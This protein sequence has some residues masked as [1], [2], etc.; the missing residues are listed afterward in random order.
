M[1]LSALQNGKSAGAAEI[2]SR[3]D[4]QIR[5]GNLKFS[6]LLAQLSPHFIQLVHTGT[7]FRRNRQAKKNRKGVIGL[8]GLQ[9]FAM[10]TPSGVPVAAS[11]T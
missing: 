6:G 2:V 8:G 10:K 9:R 7:G 3:T 5:F 4:A 1:G 11:L